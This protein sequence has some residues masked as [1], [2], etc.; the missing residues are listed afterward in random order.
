[1]IFDALVPVFAYMEPDPVTC[2]KYTWS[3]SVIVNSAS[4][5]KSNKVAVLILLSPLNTNLAPDSTT[6]LVL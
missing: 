6:T 4:P 1:M 5:L 3:E 2:D